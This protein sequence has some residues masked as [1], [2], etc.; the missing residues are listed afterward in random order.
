MSVE[1]AIR[2]LAL[3]D[4]QVST[5][6]GT[7][8]YPNPIPEQ[9]V[10]PSV[11]YQVISEVNVSSHQGNSNLAT[12]R[13]QLSLWATT[14]DNALTLKEH[15]KRVLRDYRGTVG[16]DRLDRVIWANDVSLLDPI[17]QKQQ[18]IIDLLVLHNTAY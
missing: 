7:R 14:Y 9:P 13:V 11:G 12:T 1:Y 8:W 3:A 5:L 6:I 16:S 17:T 18:R 4:G 15:L 2:S 10:Y